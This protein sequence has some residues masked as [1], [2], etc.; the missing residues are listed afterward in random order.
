MKKLI[1]IIL[2]VVLVFAFA[3]CK[4][5]ETNGVI[6]DSGGVSQSSENGEASS[7]SSADENKSEQ[8]TKETT[9]KAKETTTTPMPTTGAK[10]AIS[11]S[12]EDAYKRLSDFYGKAYHVEEKEKQ[13]DIQHYEV[14]DNMGNLYAKLEVNLKTSDV[15]ETVEHSGEV[16]TF[17]L[18]V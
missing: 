1:T 17:N 16:N 13:D 4:K 11:I 10:D 15:K 8:E 3:S 18:L 12:A 7:V 14:R 9:K 6:T 2:S 5:S